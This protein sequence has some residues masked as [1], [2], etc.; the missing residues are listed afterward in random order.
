MITILCGPVWMLAGLFRMLVGPL[1]D[2]GALLMLAGI[3]FKILAG[4]KP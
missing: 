3:P 1:N 2:S 4:K